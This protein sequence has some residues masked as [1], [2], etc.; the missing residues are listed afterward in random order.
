MARKPVLPEATLVGALSALVRP[1]EIAQPT[2]AL[3]P[4]RAFIGPKSA[5]NIRRR[6]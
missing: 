4:V 6:P 3:V 5:E 2:T 1:P